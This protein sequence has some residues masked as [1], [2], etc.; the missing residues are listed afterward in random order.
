MTAIQN[1][2]VSQ[3]LLNNMNPAKSAASATDAA[4][5]RFMTLLVTQMKNQDPLNPMDNA[6]MTSQLAQL[7]TVNGI[8]K[9][10]NTMQSLIN[11]V[12][13]SQSYQATGMIG[14]S[15]MVPGNSLQLAANDSKFGV[16]L[17]I[18]VDQL[19]V[20]IKD[21]AGTLVK[22]LNFGPQRAGVVPMNWNG[23]SDAGN[24][25]N[26]GKYT[27]EIN[28]TVAGQ[29]ATTVPLS[30]DQVAGISSSSLG[31][32]LNLKSLGAVSM[33]QIKQIQN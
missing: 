11:N 14:R 4:Q 1:N 23:Y 2:S 29:Q 22:Q 31:L 28:A 32:T 12:Q 3:S 7:S 5:D 27:F 13:S 24:N 17:P 19:T 16:E 21:A 20:S 26:E 9:L 25:M 15:V 6:Q 10:N 8:E 30:Y 33:S 18:D